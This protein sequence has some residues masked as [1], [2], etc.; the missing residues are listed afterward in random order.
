MKFFLADIREKG[1]KTLI[2]LTHIDRLNHLKEDDK[3][4][5]IEERIGMLSKEL[6][7]KDRDDFICV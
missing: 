1:I 7:I 4:I 3:L 5:L 6:D 2:I